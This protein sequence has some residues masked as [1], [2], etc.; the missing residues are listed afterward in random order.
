MPKNS[1]EIKNFGSGILTNYDKKDIPIDA[2]SH[3]WNL[4]PMSEN[5]S[6]SGIET[7]LEVTGDIIYFTKQLL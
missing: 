4:D 7:D 3:S 1:I 2:A 6:L 5:G